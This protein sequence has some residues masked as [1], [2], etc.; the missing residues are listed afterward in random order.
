MAAFQPNGIITLTTDIGHKGP[1]V[2]IM[3]GV[4]LKRFPQATLVDLTHEIS[5]HWPAEAGFWLEHAHPDFPAG[6]IHLA[7]VDPSGGTDRRFL[8]VRLADQLFLA[9][10]N[11]L[12]AN[13]ADREGATVRAIDHVQSLV[14][15]R[16]SPI[17]AG[18]DVLAPLAAEVAAGRLT[19]P[20]L[21]PKVKDWTPSWLD[22]A[23]VQDQQ[24]KGVVVAVDSFGNLIT[25]I[26]RAQIDP[27]R[28]TTVVLAG[29]R[30]PVKNTY[31]EA[32]P[33]DYM[34]L[35]NSL[36]VLEIARAEQ[37]AAEGLGLER[38]APVTAV[39]TSR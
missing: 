15:A 17:F 16:P 34:A 11:G 27:L 8:A 23:E 6:T 9:P 24:V 32:K 39:R 37:S 25:N 22:P 5:E 31:A 38:G 7:A 26:E 21:G 30:L 33:G 10:D 4:V 12:L 29:M 19:V 28:V 14:G 36:G 3:K 13:L 1:F 20:K 2:A 35:V 18:R